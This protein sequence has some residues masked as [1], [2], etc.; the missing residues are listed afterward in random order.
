MTELEKHETHICRSNLSALY[1]IAIPDV[2]TKNDNVPRLTPDCGESNKASVG[3]IMYVDLIVQSGLAIQ[4][5]TFS[6][7]LATDMFSMAKQ[8]TGFSCFS[9][10]FLPLFGTFCDTVIPS[11][12]DNAITL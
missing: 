11:R 3:R 5:T 2:Q 7:V 12:T 8:G 6:L 1:L 9:E 4:V 10:P